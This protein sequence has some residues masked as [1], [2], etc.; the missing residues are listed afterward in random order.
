MKLIME[1]WRNNILSEEYIEEGA[2]IAGYHA[3]VQKPE[4]IIGFAKINP[5]TPQHFATGAGFY[6]FRDKSR[7]I[8]RL[9]G[10]T[11]SVT[12]FGYEPYKQEHGY[13]VI[14]TLE[15][16]YDLEMLEV[17]S[18]AAVA[19]IYPFI[20]RH[21]KVFKRL[22]YD[23]KPVF[24]RV[25]KDADKITMFFDGGQMRV[26]KKHTQASVG[27]TRELDRIFY[28]MKAGNFGTLG[29]GLYRDFL[30]E[31]LK[32]VNAFKYVGP[33][34][35]PTKVEIIDSFDELIDITQEVLGGDLNTLVDKLKFLNL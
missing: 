11:A 29:R 3:T 28:N 20:E 23:N 8:Q 35:A 25:E 33:S 9:E 1:S 24:N 15:V 27:A 13:K 30:G 10:D 17:D 4:G 32:K 2:K 12:P 7:A 16:P 21:L 26:F 34:I 6:L 19:D 31:I 18:E 22:Q 5:K 14:I